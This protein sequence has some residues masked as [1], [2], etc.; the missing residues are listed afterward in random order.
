[1]TVAHIPIIEN[2][3]ARFLRQIRNNVRRRGP[4]R[5][6]TRNRRA[7]TARPAQGLRADV[8]EALTTARIGIEPTQSRLRR[9][10]GPRRG[11][12]RGHEAKRGAGGD[13]PAGRPAIPSGPS[14]PD[15]RPA[16][17]HRRTRAGRAMH[18]ARPARMRPIAAGGSARRP[19]SSAA[20]WAS[21]RGPMRACAARPA[22]P[23][24]ASAPVS[25]AAVPHAS[26][27]SAASASREKD[28]IIAAMDDRICGRD[29]L[30]GFERWRADAAERQDKHRASQELRRLHVVSSVAPGRRGAS[31]VGRSDFPG[32]D[33]SAHH[34]RAA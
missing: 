30:H 1:M 8:P 28:R 34:R 4:R 21:A 25:A 7:T 17:R 12:G 32:R 20:T 24:R 16:D 11:G 10:A 9:R 18:T 6:P 15:D 29:D 33:R 2:K 14:A 23:V 26:T 27:A 3:K 19:V 22:A 5:H 13:R 31:R